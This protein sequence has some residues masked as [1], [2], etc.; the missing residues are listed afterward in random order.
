MAAL[1][2][3]QR[4]LDEAGAVEARLAGRADAAIGE[5]RVIDI[6]DDQVRAD[7]DDGPQLA[8]AELV[9]AGE[10]LPAGEGRVPGAVSVSGCRRARLRVRDLD[11]R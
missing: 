7:D 4:P 11:H 6:G 3:V 9:E 1:R 8:V 2:A 5:Q 10:R